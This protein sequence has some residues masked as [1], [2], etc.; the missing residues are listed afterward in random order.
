M[1]IILRRISNVGHNGIRFE[2]ATAVSY[3]L[4]AG[5]QALERYAYGAASTYLARALEHLHRLPDTPQHRHQELEL[6]MTLTPAV[7]A[8]QGWAVP[9]VEQHYIRAQALCHHQG[10][11]AVFSCVGGRGV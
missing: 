9:E 5:K 11:R 7:I 1:G 2:S 3:Q 6:L 10:C 4:W 8:T